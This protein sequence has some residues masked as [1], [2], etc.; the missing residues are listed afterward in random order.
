[1]KAGK[2]K[3][4]SAC[5]SPTDREAV[6]CGFLTAQLLAIAGFFVGCLV[7]KGMKGLLEESELKKWLELVDV[8]SGML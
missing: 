5:P 6:A 7:F 1:V 3:A 4:L 2:G 8:V